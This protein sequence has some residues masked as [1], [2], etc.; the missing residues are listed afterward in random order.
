MIR[1]LTLPLRGLILTPTLNLTLTLLADS[2]GEATA[3]ALAL[4]L[5]SYL[6][7]VDSMDSWAPVTYVQ[8]V[9]ALVAITGYLGLMNEYLC[10]YEVGT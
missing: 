5:G 4:F 1:G 7:D 10:A 3:A 8:T 2:I 9:G 6:A